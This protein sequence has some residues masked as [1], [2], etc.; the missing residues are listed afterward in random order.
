VFSARW[1]EAHAHGNTEQYQLG[2]ASEYGLTQA[3]MINQRDLPLRGYMGSEAVLRGQN[4][5]VANIEWRTPL[6]DI[7]RHAMAPPVGIDRLSAAVFMDAGSVWDNG[8][9]RSRY[10][11]GVGI[12]LLGEIKVYYRI[13]LPLRLGIARGLD[14]PG[15][16]HGYLLLG[17]T[18]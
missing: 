14:E 12:E 1:T 3:P 8:N 10:Y 15:G 17:Q 2:G 5:R 7:D 16:T 9:A 6:T 11:R 18:F 4:A 13:L